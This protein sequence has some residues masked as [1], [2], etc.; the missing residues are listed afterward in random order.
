MI[1][2]LAGILATL[3]LLG[4]LAAGGTVLY[5]AAFVDAATW[6]TQVDNTRLTVAE[7]NAN[8]FDH[9]Y[10]LVGWN[11]EGASEDLSFDTSRELREDA[12]LKVETLFLRG[13][14]SWEEVA[15]EDV[16]AAAQGELEAPAAEQ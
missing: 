13:V 4:A 5:R 15:W 10:D 9:H 11:A 7:D 1:R 6:Y 12:Y 16:P 14:V 8:D 2:K 3:A